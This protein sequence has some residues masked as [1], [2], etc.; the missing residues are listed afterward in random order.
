MFEAGTFM[1]LR[2]QQEVERLRERNRVAKRFSRARQKQLE[3]AENA[4]LKAPELQLSSEN[5]NSRYTPYSNDIVVHAIQQKSQPAPTLGSIYNNS[6]LVN[7]VATTP[8]DDLT[9]PGD[10]GAVPVPHHIAADELSFTTGHD[11]SIS[12][13]DSSQQYSMNAQHF[14]SAS[15]HNSPCYS[16]LRCSDD[17][18][19]SSK[20]LHIAIRNGTVGIASLLIKAGTNVNSMDSSGSSPLHIAVEQRRLDVLELLI[21]YGANLNARNCDQMTPLE[22]AVRAQDERTVDILLGKGAQIY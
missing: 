17:D 10:N 6:E 15:S 8:S 12:L 4:S 3:L 16:K 20:L 2:E 19:N 11:Y 1:E 13:P 5:G 18:K 22:I 21:D 7:H 14:R 9:G